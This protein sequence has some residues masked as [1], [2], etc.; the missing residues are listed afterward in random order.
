MPKIIPRDLYKQ[1]LENMAIC[2]VDLVVHHNGKVLLVYRKEE[3]AKGEW[4]VP[5]GRIFKNERLKDAI[6]RKVKEETG[7]DFKD[8]KS[9]GV[10]EYFS[11]KA[12]FEDI[13]TGT[14]AVAAI[15][16]VEVDNSEVK[17]DKTSSDYRWIDKIEDNLHDYVKEAL[18]RSGVFS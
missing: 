15:Y 7:L 12:I 8:V 4:W 10:Q 2:C 18:K 13:K 5:G 17:I 9:L 3:P 16:L 11:E 14:H 6:K 1:I